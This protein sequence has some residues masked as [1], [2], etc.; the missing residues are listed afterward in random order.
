MFL[1][2]CKKNE[3]GEGYLRAALSSVTE[4]TNGLIMSTR[5][6][7]RI[8]RSRTFTVAHCGERLLRAN[9]VDETYVTTCYALPREARPA[10]S[11]DSEAEPVNNAATSQAAAAMMAAMATQ[12]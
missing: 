7:V 6:L 8:T 1:R 2:E 10:K 3:W 4:P 5:G 11:G 12:L 9:V